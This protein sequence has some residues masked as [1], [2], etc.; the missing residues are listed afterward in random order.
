MDN[1]SERGSAIYFMNVDF[2]T[3][4]PVLMTFG[5]GP[6][7]DRLEAMAQADL[8]VLIAK[9]LT[10]IMNSTIQTSDFDIERSTWRSDPNFGGAYSF[11]GVQTNL[12]HWDNIAKPLQ[13]RNWFFAGEHAYGKYRGTVHGAYLSGEVVAENILKTKDVKS[14]S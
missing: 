11:P 9:R 8:K 4:L 6:N 10:L 14:N 1:V 2:I 12:T 7:A 13:D 5:L 3:N